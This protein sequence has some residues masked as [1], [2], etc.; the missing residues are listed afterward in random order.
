MN[1]HADPRVTNGR[2]HTRL[3]DAIGLRRERAP[4]LVVLTV[5]SAVAAMLEPAQAPF[6]EWA[7]AIA[8]AAAA[9]TL[10]AAVGVGREAERGLDAMLI[11]A[12]GQPRR[13]ALRRRACAGSREPCGES[14]RSL[15]RP[16]PGSTGSC[17]IRAAR[18]CAVRATTSDS[19]PGC[20][21]SRSTWS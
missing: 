18:S 4:S 20:A 16:L 5:W 9:V 21:R 2:R 7:G 17:G 11:V 19:R 10:L 8:A 3:E 6:W 14:R 15:P 13:G 1:T 12:A